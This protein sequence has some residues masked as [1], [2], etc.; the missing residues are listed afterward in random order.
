MTN[1]IINDEAIDF[2]IHSLDSF[3]WTARDFEERETL[4]QQFTRMFDKHRID[5]LK[6]ED[7][8]PGHGVKKDCM[9]WELEWGTKKLSS[10]S[11]GS[12]FKF[13][14]ESDFAKIRAL[15][16]RVA[17]LDTMSV[18]S[19][20]GSLTTEAKKL[21][22][23]SKDIN[24]FKTGRTVIP[25]LLSIYY[26]DLFLPIFNDQDLFISK[27]ISSGLD[28]DSTGLALYL[29][30]NFVLLK[31]KEKLADTTHRTFGNFEF[32]H[33]L[34]HAFPKEQASPKGTSTE[35]EV[36]HD[37]LQGEQAVE[38][39]KAMEVPHYQF[40]LHRNFQR[41]FPKLK[42]FDEEAQMQ[43]NGQYDTEVVGIMDM[44]C[45]DENRDFVVIEIKRMATDTSIGQILRYMG[46]TKEELCKDGQKVRGLI[47]AERKDTKLEFALKI[48]PVVKFM[49]LG[50]SIALDEE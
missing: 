31:V 22:T 48:I 8:F 3:V 42:Y 45:V 26:P 38:G 20:D 27:L 35:A 14:Y 21:V 9:F 40:L 36:K 13:G 1:I 25:K 30:Y 15:I 29:E 49:R 12:R 10:I 16:Q 23:L 24:G 17:S 4:R 47:V 28:T 33:L 41:L 44:L 34:Y 37:S 7:Y 32:A 6:Q 19:K 43:K 11:G 50:L 5:N 18:Y 46:W 2:I 39:Y